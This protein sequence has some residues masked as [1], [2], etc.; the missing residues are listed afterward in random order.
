MN[1]RSQRIFRHGGVWF[2]RQSN[3]HQGHD[4]TKPGAYF[5]TITAES[6]NRVFGGML[7]G[8]LEL[9]D[10][11][12]L[13]RE[14]WSTLPVHCPWVG[15]GDAVVMPDHFHGIVHILASS[16]VR[17]GDHKDR[18]YLA[19]R[20]KGT[21]PNSVGRAVQAFKSLTTRRYIEKVRADRWTRYEG[22]LWQRGYHDRIIRDNAEL[23]RAQQYIRDNPRRWM[24]CRPRVQG[25]R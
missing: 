4:Y 20:P 12:W 15:I 11:G 7:D 14:A 16:P 24:S 13:V 19:G 23:E 22:R 1:D 2:D 5:V 10:I 9:N 21:V 3:R 17:E 18:P 8:R 6:R 25:E